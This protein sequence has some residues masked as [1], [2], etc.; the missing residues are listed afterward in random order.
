MLKKKKKPARFVSRRAARHTGPSTTIKLGLAVALLTG[1][2][3]TAY[4]ALNRLTQV[5]AEEQL[6]ASYCLERNDQPVVAVF[7]DGSFPKSLGA[8]Q[9]RDYETALEQAYDV[10]APNTRFDFFTTSE[11]FSG[12]VA[13]PAVIHCKPPETSEGYAELD[14]PRHSGPRA[15]V[16]AEEAT[17]AWEANVDRLMEIATNPD[18]AANHSPLMEMTNA[19]SRYPG[20]GGPDVTWLSFTDGIQN[21]ELAQFCAVKGHMPSYERFAR[22]SEFDS[23]RPASLDGVKVKLFLVEHGK[24]PSPDLPYCSNE[25]MRSWWGDYFKGSGAQSVE[26]TR[27]RNWGQ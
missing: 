25:E 23:V 18:L 1:T 9:M 2:S 17:E 26:I 12:S 11:G 6:N 20:F 13:K 14:G 10:A 27:I 21:S 19:I 7:F 5:A 3:A 4:V 15:K 8:Q 24:L 16:I 22:R